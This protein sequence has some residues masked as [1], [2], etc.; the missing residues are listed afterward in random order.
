MYLGLLE[1]ASECSNYIIDLAGTFWGSPRCIS[2]AFPLQQEIVI[3]A[4]LHYNRPGQTQREPSDFSNFN[5]YHC[6]I[7]H[8]CD[9]LQLW[10]SWDMCGCSCVVTPRSRNPG[11]DDWERAWAKAHVKIQK[12]ERGIR[13]HDPCVYPSRSSPRLQCLWSSTSRSASCSVWRS[14]WSTR[15]SCIKPTPA[16]TLL[17]GWR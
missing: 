13:S 2:K 10:D 14:T 5:S 1:C 11:W 7:M 16:P 8:Q 4:F 12:R 17:R 6:F 3:H 9:Q 15:S